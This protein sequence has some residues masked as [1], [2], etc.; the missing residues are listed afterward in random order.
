MSSTNINIEKAVAVLGAGGVI[1]Y[2]IEYCFGLGCDPKNEAAVQ[3]ILK[4]KQRS[5]A[6]GLILVAADSS[7]VAEYAEFDSLQRKPEILRSWPGPNTWVLPATSATPDW[8]SGAHASVAMRV[9]DHPLVRLICA[10]F[11]GA[12]VSTSAN[13]HGQAALVEAQAV[14]AE[15]GSELDLIVAGTISA[16]AS[17]QSASNIFDAISGKQLR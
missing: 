15:M 10:G 11:G 3:R 13:R 2:P 14:E 8:I 17:S 5:Q 16:D 9:T 12:I 1:A 6:Q 4:I 7:Q